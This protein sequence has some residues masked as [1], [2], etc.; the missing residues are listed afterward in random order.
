MRLLE[1]SMQSALP[2][3]GSL[4]ECCQ[5]CVYVPDDSGDSY[6][7]VCRRILSLS[8]TAQ[9]RD[10]RH[11]LKHAGL[12]ARLAT[13]PMR[14]AHRNDVEGRAAQGHMHNRVRPKVLSPVRFNMLD[15][16]QATQMHVSRAV[17]SITQHLC[18]SSICVPQVKALVS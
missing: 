14:N 17:A 11:S 4:A 6:S 8:P 5:C 9:A 16:P 15:C 13:S 10:R 1:A 7:T 2:A 18:P 12:P 3:A